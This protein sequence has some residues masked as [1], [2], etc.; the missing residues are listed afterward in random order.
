MAIFK[1]SLHSWQR[2]LTLPFYE[3]PP[4]CCLP[5][6]PFFRF[7]QHTPSPPLPCHLQPPP[8]LFFLLSCFYGWMG[9]HATFDVLFYL[10]I[11]WIYTYQALVPCYQKELDVCFMQQ[12]AKFTE[13][14]HTQCGFLLVLW[15]D[16]NYT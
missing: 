9:Y 4:L 7:C 13:V 3:D 14:W 1:V 11:I 2:V 10:M 5:P 6:H 16:I 8:P 12:G 15:F